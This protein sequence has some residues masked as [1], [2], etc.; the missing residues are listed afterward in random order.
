MLI[1][2]KEL[3][4]TN[5][6]VLEFAIS[7]WYKLTKTV[8]IEK[9]IT[10]EEAIEK[11]FTIKEILENEIDCIAIV[12]TEEIENEEEPIEYIERIYRQ[13]ALDDIA[14][15]LEAF[16]RKQLWTDEKIKKEEEKAKKELEKQIK[17]IIN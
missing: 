17:N 10:R 7:K 11:D 2:W 9:E 15:F 6:Q 5:E 8:E 14:I 4:V 3:N 13:P 16:I 12:W 1:L